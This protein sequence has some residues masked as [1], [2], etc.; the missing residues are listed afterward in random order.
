MLI[1]A[2]CHLDRYLHKRFGSTILPILRQIEEHQ[3]LTISNSLDLTSYKINCRIARKNRYVIPAFGIHPRNAH[4]YVDRVGLVKKLISKTEI[5]GEIGLDHYYVKES[6]RYSA[7]AKIFRFF[8]SE[9]RDKVVSVHTKGAERA[10]L[11]LLRR[12]ENEKVIIHW[13]SGD[14]EV[15]ADMIK[16][17]YYFSIVPEVK[18]SAV[19]S[20][21][22][23]NLLATSKASGCSR[24]RARLYLPL[25]YGVKT[26]L[27][28]T[29]GMLLV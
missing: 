23:I 14:L 3:I 29:P 26:A 24:L 25:L 20:D 17:G 15:L 22:D 12:Y 6:A 7:Q 18:F 1:D 4:R 2:H 13:F 28:F 10:A 21:Q 9:T 8:L 16:E 11:A 5:V 19:I 27:R